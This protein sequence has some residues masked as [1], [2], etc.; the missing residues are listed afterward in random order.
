MFPTDEAG[1][2]N[3]QRDPVSRSALV[4]DDD[5][6]R[7]LQLRN[8]LRQTGLFSL[9]LSCESEEMARDVLQDNPEP[10][11]A[12]AIVALELAEDCLAHIPADLLRRTVITHEPEDAPPVGDIFTL[13]R[14][15]SAA[16]IEDV[17]ARLA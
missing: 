15:I 4:I 17:L 10:R 5:V 2:S 12:L 1:R 11:F 9:I 6:T 16:V 13:P 3:G 14:P 8:A 7:Q